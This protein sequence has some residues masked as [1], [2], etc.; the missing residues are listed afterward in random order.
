MTLPADNPVPNQVQNFEKLPPR[1]MSLVLQDASPEELNFFTNLLAEQ[2][3]INPGYYLLVSVSLVAIVLGLIFN[4]YFLA[5]LAALV[6]PLALPF[7]GVDVHAAK[8]S[9]RSVLLM[10]LHLLITALL[11]YFS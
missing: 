6:A 2:N 4:S 1:K 7:I 9:F 5:M 11:Y 3:Q 8:Q 10:L